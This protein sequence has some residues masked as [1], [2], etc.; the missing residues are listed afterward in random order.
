MQATQA[1]V[2]VLLMLD[3]CSRVKDLSGG[4]FDLGYGGADRAWKELDWERLDC[5]GLDWILLD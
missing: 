4:L 3:W 1:F 5:T 2:R